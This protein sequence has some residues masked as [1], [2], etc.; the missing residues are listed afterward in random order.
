MSDHA[1][2]QLKLRPSA[3]PLAFT[4][5]GS[6]HIFPGEVLID[7]AG[8]P[9]WVGNASHEGIADLVR[10]EVNH[11]DDIDYS[12]LADKHGCGEY[13][14][15]FLVRTGW[16]MLRKIR[17]GMPEELQGAAA[18][19]ED[20]MTAVLAR[21]VQLPGTA[22]VVIDGGRIVLVIDWKSGRKDNDHRHQLA[23][24]AECAWQKYPKAEIVITVIA[25]LRT[26]EVE[27]ETW[28]REKLAAWGEK[29]QS[30]VI[31]WD[32]IYHPSPEN[33]TNC[34]RA[35]SC[36]ARQAITRSVVRDFTSDEFID[37]VISAL[38]E[39]EPQRIV[40]LYAAAGTAEKLA[41]QLKDAIKQH[42][43]ISGPVVGESRQLDIK[44]SQG[45]KIIPLV[46]WP[47]LTEVFTAEEISYAVTLSLPKLEGVAKSKA[48]A[49]SKGSAAKELVDSL[50]A[51][52]AFEYTESYR[53]NES[54][55]IGVL[56][57]KTEHVA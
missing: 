14:L 53:M 6:V 49:G 10:G 50:T 2:P 45:K 42:V 41:K 35:Y 1:L 48:K 57:D 3:L 29:L 22:D 31:E 20:Q 37:Q 32:G 36:P 7:T 27:K 5:P 55:V 15:P 25:W 40:D 4:C 13:D 52:N 23:G 8:E 44:E 11:P 12:K 34:P 9:A 47:W 51:M 38:P 17:E 33:C 16:S 26:F 28:T 54:R 21:G 56:D 30:E 19:A 18:Q 39:L 46:A 24:Y 43:R